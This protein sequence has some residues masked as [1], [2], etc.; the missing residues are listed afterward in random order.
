MLSKRTCS[1]YLSREE[2]AVHCVL[3][4]PCV[5]LPPM[6]V[7]LTQPEVILQRTAFKC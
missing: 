2:A 5:A 7:E 6:E 1:S 4:A 3:R